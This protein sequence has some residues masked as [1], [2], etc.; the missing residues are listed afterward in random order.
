MTI[1]SYPLV[2]IFDQSIEYIDSEEGMQESLF[3]LSE[4]QIKTATCIYP[5][6]NFKALDGEQKAPYNY[7]DLTLLVQQKLVSEG[8]CC[9]AKIQ[10]TAIEQVFNLMKATL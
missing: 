5:D 9:T 6:G 1:K 3:Y 2:L 10:I 8:Q 4:N 7:D